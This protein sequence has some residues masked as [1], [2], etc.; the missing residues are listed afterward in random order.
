MRASC[1]LTGT[2]NLPST[3][4]EHS[5]G[6]NANL[7]RL[8]KEMVKPFHQKKTIVSQPFPPLVQSQARQGLLTPFT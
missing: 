6:E 4:M 5:R 8:L 1:R 3:N 2:N 7:K